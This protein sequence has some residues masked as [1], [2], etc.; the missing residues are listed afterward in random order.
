[1]RYQICFAVYH[2]FKRLAECLSTH[3][4]DHVGGLPRNNRIEGFHELLPRHFLIP[5]P[6]NEN[7]TDQCFV[8]PHVSSYFVN[9]C[10]VDE[11]HFHP[12]SETLDEGRSDVLWPSNLRLYSLRVLILI[13]CHFKLLC[14]A[15]IH[16]WIV[17]LITEDDGHRVDVGSRE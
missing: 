8:I 16:R 15:F 3:I 10:N 11:K 2:T 9:S 7:Q 12:G 14:I 1:M 4:V 17:S 13:F 6:M 5:I